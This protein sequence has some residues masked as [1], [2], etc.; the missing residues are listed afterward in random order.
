M[1]TVPDSVR[2]TDI[3]ITREELMLYD[4][5]RR[6]DAMRIEYPRTRLFWAM[7]MFATPLFS[8]RVTTLDFYFRLCL[9]MSSATVVARSPMMAS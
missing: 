9:F 5:W 4:E 3:F 8:L 2:Q 7:L 1:L 6:W